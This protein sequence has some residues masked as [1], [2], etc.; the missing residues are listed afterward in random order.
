[1]TEQDMPSRD[2]KNQN[3]TISETEAHHPSKI[4]IDFIL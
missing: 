1:M 4:P 2:K 3:A